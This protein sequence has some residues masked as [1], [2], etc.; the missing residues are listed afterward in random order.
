M[1]NCLKTQLKESVQN[2][3]LPTFNYA[4][5]K[6]HADSPTLVSHFN[7]QNISNVNGQLPNIKLRGD[8]YFVDKDGNNIGKELNPMVYGSFTT[9]DENP[10][11]GQFQGIQVMSDATLEIRYNSTSLTLDNSVIDTRALNNSEIDFNQIGDVYTNSYSYGIVS[12][13]WIA[14]V[15]KG[16]I[17]NFLNNTKRLILISATNDGSGVTG[18]LNSVESKDNTTLNLLQ[19]ANLTNVTGDLDK[20]LTNLSHHSYQGSTYQ[21]HVAISNC[22]RIKY[23][24]EFI[25]DLDKTF[26][27]NG[28]NHTW[29]EV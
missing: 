20:F 27:I 11:N 2:E 10:T 9:T 5:I 12:F 13:W 3:M 6:L 4:Q 29:S 1:G 8:A 26:S 25:T 28:A 23:K 17:Q 16:S 15:L 19:L 7:F 24:G 14:H 21:I 22:P 18:D